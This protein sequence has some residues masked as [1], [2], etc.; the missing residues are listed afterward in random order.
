MFQQLQQSA[1]YGAEARALV[2]HAMAD[3]T[4]DWGDTN[5]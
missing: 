1:V 2:T 5:C 3:L 4:S